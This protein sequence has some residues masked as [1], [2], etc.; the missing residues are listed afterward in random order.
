MSRGPEKNFDP[1][2]ALDKA[3]TLF[4]ENGYAAT[5]LSDLLNAMGIGRKSLYDTFGSK[6][7][8]F[9]KAI[10]H[11]SD[12]VV[13]DLSDSLNNPSEPALEN[14]RSTMRKLSNEH[15]QKNS[16]GCL[17]GVSMAQ[18][19]TD[20]TE[21]SSVLRSH[22][23]RVEKAYSRAFERAQA[24]GD[25]SPHT[26]V[27]NL[28]RLFMSIHQGLALIGRVSDSNDVQAGIVEGALATLDAS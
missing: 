20:D 27:T 25:L 1:D 4:R 19:R 26:N 21:V 8:L 10:E 17:L 5:S 16:S 18:F 9:L 12:T 6:R 22:M 24:E 15:S 14:I 28:A 7:A 2:I 3:M 23:G 13:A 11:Y